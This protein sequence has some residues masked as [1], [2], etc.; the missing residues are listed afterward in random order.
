VRL[1]V[2]DPLSVHV[3]SK[4]K[5]K[6]TIRICEGDL[7]IELVPCATEKYIMFV[8]CLLNLISMVII[9][10]FFFFNLTQGNDFFIFLSMFMIF[11]P[12]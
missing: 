9:Y 4:N 3:A 1:L 5:K 2:Q 10:T 11:L 7:I 8:F 12:G 6:N